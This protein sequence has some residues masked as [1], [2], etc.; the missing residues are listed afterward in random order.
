V[1]DGLGDP[2]QEPRFPQSQGEIM[3]GRIAVSPVQAELPDR[4]TQMV[5]GAATARE[6][7]WTD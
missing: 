6:I 5:V 4:L 3:A 7:G 2:L 1:P